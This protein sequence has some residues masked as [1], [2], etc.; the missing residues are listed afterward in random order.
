MN[1]IIWK[2][3]QAVIIVQLESFKVMMSW[4]LFLFKSRH[5]VTEQDVKEWQKAEVKFQNVRIQMNENPSFRK[6][7]ATP[8][9]AF[10]KLENIYNATC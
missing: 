6:D 9:S 8:P 4:L 2:R 1:L 10:Q 5:F 7:S 3:A